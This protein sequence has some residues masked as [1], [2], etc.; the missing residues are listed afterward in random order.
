MATE[1]IQNRASVLVENMADTLTHTFKGDETT[2]KVGQDVQL[3]ADN[4]VIAT[5]DGATMPIGSII[6]VTQSG[7]IGVSTIFSCIAGGVASGAGC[8]FGVKVRQNGTL[9]SG[10]PQ[11]VVAGAGTHAT[12][13]ILKGGAD[14]EKITIGKLFS[15]VIV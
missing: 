10:T 14:T 3:S 9:T 8:S 6:S 2:L 7:D 11:Y 12:G 5:T 4:T 15:P 1:N 13:I